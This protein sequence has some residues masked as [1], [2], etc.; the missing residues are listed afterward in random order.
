MYPR[1]SDFINDVFGTNI[2]LPIQSYGFFLA[3]AFITAGLLLRSEL[4]RKELAGEVFPVKKRTP[5]AN[6]HP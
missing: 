6:L 4:K 2:N 5:L 1:V 3:L